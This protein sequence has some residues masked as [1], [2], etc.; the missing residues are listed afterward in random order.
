MNKSLFFVLIS[1]SL[2]SCDENQREGET[3]PSIGSRDLSIIL[4]RSIEALNILI[5]NNPTE[6][7]A[8]YKRAALT[9]EKQPLSA[10]EDIN[11]AIALE[12]SHVNYFFL[13]S[14]ILK[15]LNRYEDA[16]D[17]ASDAAANGLDSPLFYSYIAKLYFDFDSLQLAQKYADVALNMV[18]NLNEALLVKAAIE[19]KFENPG[20]ALLILNKAMEHYPE[21]PDIYDLISKSYLKQGKLE[22]AFRSNERGISLKGFKH[23]GLMH[24]QAKLWE[25]LGKS[26]SAMV[27]YNHLIAISPSSADPHIDIAEMDFAKGY[28]R[29]AFSSFEKAINKSP[30]QKSIYLRA[31][32]CL[33]RLSRLKEAQK[34]Y[35]KAKT[36]FPDDEAISSALDKMT[37]LVEH[38]YRSTNFIK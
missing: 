12:S 13:K 23:K 11:Q 28:Y 14:R 33:E 3:M 6:A 8:Y 34:F 18:P 9:T 10:L 5:D 20:K 15:K 16:L 37:N 2:T 21:N 31:G 29:R 25:I 24:N 32:Y 27:Y 30:N 7:E 38:E 26:D 22:S 4:S 19:I 1:L 36:R 17:E 35:L